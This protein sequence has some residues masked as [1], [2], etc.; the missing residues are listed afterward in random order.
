V[1]AY[2]LGYAITRRRTWRREEDC[3]WGGYQS[4]SLARQAW[5]D[6]QDAVRLADVQLAVGR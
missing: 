2:A 4:D 5:D 1:F 6:G 3:S